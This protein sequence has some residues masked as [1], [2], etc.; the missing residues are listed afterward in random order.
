VKPE[1][2]GVLPAAPAAPPDSAGRIRVCCFGPLRIAFP[3]GHEI[4]PGDWGSHKARAIFAYL[5][6]HRTLE[7]GVPRER[8]LEA[9]WPDAPLNSV[10]ST[11]HA[12][13]AI[14]R[15]TLASVEVP[16]P[17]AESAWAAVTHSGGCYRLAFRSEPWIDC[18]AF[19]DALRDGERWQ[20]QGNYFR[21]LAALR[22][23]EAL[24]LADFLEDSYQDWT[25]A[26]RDRYRRDYADLLFRLGSLALETWRPAETVEWSSKLL[27]LDPL[28][29]RACRIGMHALVALGRRRA[30]LDLYQRFS[31]RLRDDIGAE[32]EALT[33]ETERRIR[34]GQPLPAIAPTMAPTGQSAA[35]VSLRPRR[36]TEPG[37]RDRP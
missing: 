34:A 9:I 22:Q 3:A 2:A 28:D 36:G 32:P 21:A 16:P 11:Y 17:A 15:K 23:A 13:L 33:V 35:R 20:R 18:A 14:L 19:E 26:L 4:G 1:L 24:Y 27:A 6:F 31:K 7:P 10:E 12:T 37:S 8:I 25:D 30:A 29:E 5:L